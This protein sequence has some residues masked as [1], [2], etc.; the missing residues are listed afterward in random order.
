M[1]VLFFEWALKMNLNE[2]QLEIIKLT[3]EK[4]LSDFD[5]RLRPQAE[6]LINQVEDEL[7]NSVCLG[8]PARLDQHQSWLQ[9]K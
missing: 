9:E 8:S 2:T 7:W 1:N 5:D 3:V 4:S 6:A